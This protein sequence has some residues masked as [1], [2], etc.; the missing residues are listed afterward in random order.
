MHLRGGS[1]KG[2]RAMTRNYSKCQCYIYWM[3]I[4]AYSRVI[5]QN[6]W[7]IPTAYPYLL[8]KARTGKSLFQYLRLS[9]LNEVGR[10][11]IW[12][13]AGVQVEAMEA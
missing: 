11:V 6:W 4:L 12:S 2:V 9:L 8:E 1:K 13:T 7:I 3:L 10:K 5:L